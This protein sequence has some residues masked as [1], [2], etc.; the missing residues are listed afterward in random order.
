[1]LRRFIKYFSAMKTGRT[2][3][4]A[5]WDCFSG[6]VK[7]IKNRGYKWL[8]ETIDVC[9]C[10]PQQVPFVGGERMWIYW[11]DICLDYTPN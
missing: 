3:N 10:Y 1:M 4:L 6:D 11:Y 9:M 7:I 8:I 2:V 5:V